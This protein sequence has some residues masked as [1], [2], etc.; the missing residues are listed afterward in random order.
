MTKVTSIIAG[1][2]FALGL[3]TA[4]HAEWKPEKPIRIIV[5]YAAGGVTDQ[6]VRVVAQEM[7]PALGQSV[8]VVNQPG[9]AGSV[10]TQAVMD[11]PK[12]GYTWLSGGVRDIGTY[13]VVGTLDTK[14]TDWEPFVVATITGILSVNADNAAQSLEE[15]V[16]S[17]KADP[18]AMRVATAG[19][20]STGGQALGALASIAGITPEQLV[21]DGDN[22]AVLAT[23]SGEAQATTQLSLTQA[24][25]IRAGKLRPLAVFSSSPMTLEGAGTIPSIN[26]TYPD[27]AAT[28]NFVGIYLPKDVPEEVLETLASVWKETLSKSEALATLCSTRGCGINL[29]A[30]DEAQAASMPLVQAAAWGIFDRKEHAVSP[31]DVGIPPLK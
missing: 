12:D 11:A 19:I 5:P 20:N 8:V 6:I 17:V 2:I 26:D 4:A 3:G 30:R 28:E 21:Y 14:L 24:E 27:I 18:Q 13:A 23:V 1:A 9:A 16:S 15:F 25:M 22:P 29:M 10:G 7:E 31:A